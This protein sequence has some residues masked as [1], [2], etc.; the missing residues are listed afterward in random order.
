M[1][2]RRT[3]WRWLRR[4]YWHHSDSWPLNMMVRFLKSIVLLAMWLG[5]GWGVFQVLMLSSL[6]Q[7]KVEGKESI[8]LLGTLLTALI[9]FGV[10]QWRGIEEDERQEREKIEKAR[11]EI[12]ELDAL[13]QK[14][15]SG[16]ARRYVELRGRSG[17][18]QKGLIRD[19]LEEVWEK[20]PVE[21]QHSVAI[22]K[23]FPESRHLTWEQERRALLWAYEHLDDD[24]QIQVT[25]AGRVRGLPPY[26]LEARELWAV[27]GIWP[28]VGLGTSRLAPSDCEL[29]QG[30][31]FLGLSKNP[32]GPTKAE[33]LPIPIETFVPPPGWGK[34]RQHQSGLFITI[35]G[36]GRTTTALHLCMEALRKREAFPIYWRVTP[37]QASNWNTLL[38]NL[39]QT[40]ARTIARYVAI[41]PVAL[42]SAPFAQKM[43]MARLFFA[44]LPTDPLSFL[45]QAGLSS[46]GQG[47]A[48]Q[49]TIA[50][51]ARYP[52]LRMPVSEPERFHVL[53]RGIP[54]GFSRLWVIVDVQEE[55][56]EALACTLYSLAEELER[57]KIIFQA[58]LCAS[59][60]AVL[61]P[62][63][64]ICTWSDDALRQL[65]TRRLQVLSGDDTLDAWCDLRQWQH[66][67]STAEDRLVRAARGS[68]AR[69]IHL[70]N[71][72]L[73]RIGQTKKKLRPKDLTIVG[74]PP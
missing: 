68:P 49:E 11:N 51:Y 25:D 5:V 9:G 31:R 4:T 56:G 10:Q 58:F 50:A 45:Q 66:R 69:L 12:D 26:E 34:M 13:L 8:A 42:T 46:V 18:W 17:V 41:R 37:L 44:Y 30:I 27:I 47:M 16:G 33:C 65:L 57:L 1:S 43:A 3:L 35:P 28:K 32:F 64:E 48:V 71:R 7:L 23:G 67:S 14:D 59:N 19:R 38:D 20:T 60:P 70:G 53:S 74:G 40:V 62:Y 63:G 55:S 6:Q 22:V 61:S 73:C 29:I 36:G 72:L 52:S 39:M 2:R 21:L 24:W 15:L 54:G